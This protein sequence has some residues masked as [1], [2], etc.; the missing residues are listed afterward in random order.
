MY[1]VIL[2]PLSNLA[3]SRSE[4]PFQFKW[5]MLFY[6]GRMNTSTYESLIELL[7]KIST[8]PL[9]QLLSLSLRLARELGDKAFEKWC[10]LEIDG[11]FA[12]NLAMTSDVVVPEYRTVVG[13]YSDIY[14]R[15]FL[16][17]DPQLQFINAYR[18]RIGVKQ[19][20]KIANGSKSYDVQD[21]DILE[22]IRENLKVDVHTFTFSP[23][24]VAGVLS[25]IHSKLSDWLYEIRR[26]QSNEIEE[27]EKLGVI[28][29]SDGQP[30][31]QPHQVNIIVGDGV[32]ISGDFVVASS[33][34]NSFHKAQSANITEELKDLLQKLAKEV[35]KM[36]EALPKETAEQ[37]A[38]DLEMFIAE[39]TSQA[40]RKKWWQLS[41]EG[42]KRA[43][44]DVRDIGKP[45]LELVALIVPL[46]VKK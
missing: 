22:N 14:G 46:L 44:Q 31:G 9:S 12:D 28:N 24:A 2:R 8:A 3:R 27:E 36:S 4:L 20:E 38:R 43:A 11:Y 42:L 17:R 25:S 15:P 26:D 34:V 39:A 29:L 30:I 21:F 16:I 35:G 40:P 19:L 1:D 5:T 6:R 10:R 41:V 13:Q 7:G 32:T 23:V 37:V 18:L 33:I 45:V